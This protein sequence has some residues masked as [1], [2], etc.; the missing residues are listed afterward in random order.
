MKRY[1]SFA[2]LFVAVVL[3]Q[4]YLFDNISLGIYFHPLIYSAFIILLPLK[5][6]SGAVLLL[7]AFLGFVMD[8]LMGM[9]GLNV[10]AITTA[11]FVRP[12]LIKLICGY[13]GVL[14]E[15]FPMI[16]RVGPKRLLMYIAGMV[17][18]HCSTYFLVE[19][20]SLMHVMHTL[21]RIVVSGAASILVVWY[22]VRLFLD[23]IMR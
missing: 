16:N 15:P 12:L 22:I 3:L 17:M 1:L 2:M 5:Y 4:I 10:I 7:S 21:L 6:N 8:W 23:K 20:L 14:S 19:S 11:G 9:A 18:V 13:G